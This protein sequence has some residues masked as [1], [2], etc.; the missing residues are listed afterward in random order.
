MRSH[1]DK[2]WLSLEF[3]MGCKGDQAP[4]LYYVKSFTD[5]AS[6]FLKDWKLLRPNTSPMTSCFWT[7]QQKLHRLGSSRDNTAQ[8]VA[9]TLTSHGHWAFEC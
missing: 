9:A 4:L 6:L 7:L 3:T 2:L 1:L 5:K 8:T